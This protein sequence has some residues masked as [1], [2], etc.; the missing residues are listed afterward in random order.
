MGRAINKA[1]TIAEILKRK[2][3]LHQWN[4][5]SSL[6]MIDVFEPV[7]EGLDVVESRRYVSCLTIILSLSLLTDL[8]M[9]TNHSGYQPPLPSS[10]MPPREFLSAPPRHLVPSSG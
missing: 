3:P 4:V 6:E 5:L 2:M 9:G 1:V 8:D 10:D 7:E